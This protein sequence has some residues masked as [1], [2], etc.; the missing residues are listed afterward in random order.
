MD[1][2]I[3]K[4]SR[5]FRYQGGKDSWCWKIRKEWYEIQE[6]FQK[7]QRVAGEYKNHQ[8]KVHSLN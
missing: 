2:E 3:K 5:N 7:N 1:E 8:Y 6:W 4:H